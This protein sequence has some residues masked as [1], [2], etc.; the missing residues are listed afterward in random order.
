VVFPED[1]WNR[2]WSH[3]W[4][5]CDASRPLIL[6]ETVTNAQRDSGRPSAGLESDGQIAEALCGTRRG[7]LRQR[8][9]KKQ[10]PP[11]QNL[12]FE[13]RDFG[14]GREQCKWLRWE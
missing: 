10:T 5:A 1:V 9:S 3:A 8:R 4:I 2:E 14:L 13:G 11:C 12:N 7:S 6:E